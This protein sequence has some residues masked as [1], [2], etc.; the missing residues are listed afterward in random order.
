MSTIIPTVTV[1][2][3][4]VCA[5]KILCFDDNGVLSTATGFFF[6]MGVERIVG[7]PSLARSMSLQDRISSNSSQA[8]LIT[9]W[10]V[11]SGKHFISRRYLDTSGRAPTYLQVI[12][13]H[14]YPKSVVD[15]LFE[16]TVG[17]ED[18]KAAVDDLYSTGKSLHGPWRVRCEIYNDDRSV[19]LW[20][21]HSKLKSNCDVVAIPFEVPSEAAKRIAYANG[22]APLENLQAGTAAFIVG[23]PN[24]LSAG[25][26][27]PVWKSGYVAS[28]PNFN[29]SIGTKPDENFGE[30][31]G[32]V[33]PA[34]FIDSLTRGGMSGSPVFAATRMDIATPPVYHFIG[35]YSGRIEGREGEAAFG[36]CWRRDVLREIISSAHI[37]DHPHVN[38][39]PE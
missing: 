39:L 16:S 23:F 4:S 6:S 28:E 18:K 34:F 8:Y 2:A 36:I 25:H 29:I 17:H 19:P 1:S 31:G 22:S 13:Q 7:P 37:G 35:T 30:I 33:L 15:F 38:F 12:L 5:A 3:P 32:T 11:V 20:L 9:N 27:L 24:G 21:E 10:H 14:E 26:W